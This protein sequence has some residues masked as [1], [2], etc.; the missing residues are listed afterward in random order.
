MI[1]TDIIVLSQY[2][3]KG[4]PLTT[5]AAARQIWEEEHLVERGCLRVD[6]SNIGDQDLSADFI[7]EFFRLDAPEC[8]VVW[9]SPVNYSPEV[10]RM[11]AGYFFKLKEMREAT[12]KEG[13]IEA[14]LLFEPE[15][16]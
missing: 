7:K 8:R 5:R 4:H 3:Q 10:G 12:I 1:R 13:F 16:F 6:F 14:N 11:L 2:L 15:K 9:L